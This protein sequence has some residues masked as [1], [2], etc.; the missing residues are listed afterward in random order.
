[1]GKYLSLIAVVLSSQWFAASSQ[2]PAWIIAQQAK[3]INQIRQDIQQGVATCKASLPV[4]SHDSSPLNDRQ[5]L[6]AS[7]PFRHVSR[8]RQS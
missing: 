7:S 8:N 5:N 2:R 1:M 4:A 3:T 6:D